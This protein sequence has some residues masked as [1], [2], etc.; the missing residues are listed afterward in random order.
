VSKRLALLALLGWIAACWREEQS[1]A[2]RDAQRAPLAAC[3]ASYCDARESYC[4]IYLS[5]VPEPPT[6]YA[7]RPLPKACKPNDDATPSC[8]CFPPDTP[9][10]SFCGPLPTGGGVTAFH[11]T[12]QGKKPP[13]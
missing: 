2:A 12:C 7:C 3:G 13:H 1:R 9:C 8:D 6:D 4:E 5:D 10:L 11:L